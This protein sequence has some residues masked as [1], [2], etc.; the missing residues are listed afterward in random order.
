MKNVDSKNLAPDQLLHYVKS[1]THVKFGTK[2]EM[3]LSMFQV[4]RAFVGGGKGTQVI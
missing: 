1:Q 3:P 2:F 4:Q